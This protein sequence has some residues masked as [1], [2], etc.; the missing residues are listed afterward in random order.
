ME[1]KLEVKS[2]LGKVN[3]V[4]VQMPVSLEIMGTGLTRQ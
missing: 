1:E 4:Q 2:N 3:I